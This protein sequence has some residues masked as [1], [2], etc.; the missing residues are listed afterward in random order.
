MTT[1]L[2]YVAFQLAAPYVLALAVPVAVGYFICGMV[3]T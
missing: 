2:T 3:M 1:I